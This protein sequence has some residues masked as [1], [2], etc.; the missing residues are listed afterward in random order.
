VLETTLMGCA[1]RFDAPARVA[2]TGATAGVATM[3][4]G[5]GAAATPDGQRPAIT[6]ATVDDE[7]TLAVRLGPRDDWF[8]AAELFVA[9][10]TVSPVST[11]PVPGWPAPP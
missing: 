11:G 2:V 1:L 7:L 10:Y 4:T 8:V 9:A 3:P 6:T 5:H